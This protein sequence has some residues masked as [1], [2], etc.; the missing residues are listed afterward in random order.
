VLL[1]GKPA[2]TNSSTCNC[3]WGGVITIT[4]PGQN[5]VVLS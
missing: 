2:L 3:V 4:N 5:T 1:G